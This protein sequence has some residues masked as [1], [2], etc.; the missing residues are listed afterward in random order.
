MHSFFPQLLQH[1]RSLWN[2]IHAGCV[3]A[4]ASAACGPKRN[5]GSTPCCCGTEQ[6]TTPGEKRKRHCECPT[7]CL[8]GK[9][10]PPALHYT[11]TLAP[12]RG[13]VISHTGTCAAYHTASSRACLHS[14]KD[15]VPPSSMFLRLL[16]PSGSL[17]V[18]L[19]VDLIAPMVL[20]ARYT[21]PG[22]ETA[23]TQGGP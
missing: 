1:S 6:H 15:P 18:S 16:L 7:S 5:H 21:F 2:Q 20:V 4:A 9:H 13:H 12:S 14:P 3:V 8:A 10:Y 17:R 19:I 22:Q 23:A 11:G